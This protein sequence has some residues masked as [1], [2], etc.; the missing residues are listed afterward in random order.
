MDAIFK[1]L[2]CCSKPESTAGPTLCLKAAQ[3]LIPPVTAKIKKLPV[4]FIQGDS[5]C[6]KVTD[7]HIVVLLKHVGS[8]D[9]TKCVKTALKVCGFERDILF[10]ITMTLFSNFKYE[11]I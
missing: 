5:D 7:L 3:I 4:Q 8:M 2:G 9:G 1:S 6:C 11:R 10:F